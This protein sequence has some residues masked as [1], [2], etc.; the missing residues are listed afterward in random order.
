MGAQGMEGGGPGT[1][2][3]TVPMRSKLGK[4]SSEGPLTSMRVC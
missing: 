2:E 4:D 3:E 1:R